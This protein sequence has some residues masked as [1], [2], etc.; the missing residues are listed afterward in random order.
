MNDCKPFERNTHKYAFWNLTTEEYLLGRGLVDDSLSLSNETRTRG[1]VSRSTALS[2]TLWKI[3]RLPRTTGGNGKRDSDVEESRESPNAVPF[4]RRLMAERP[5]GD[6]R[7]QRIAQIV[8]RELCAEIRKNQ[9]MCSMEV[10]EK[11]A[12]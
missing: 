4:I 6:D 5:K 1:D 8:C 12:G 9:R 11:Y 3:S 10:S 2:D 7:K